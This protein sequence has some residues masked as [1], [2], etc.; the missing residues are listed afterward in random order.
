MVPLTGAPLM[1][2]WPPSCSTRSRIPTIPSEVLD[3]RSLLAD[4]LA[5]IAPCAAN[6]SA[7]EKN[8]VRPSLVREIAERVVVVKNDRHLPRN[9]CAAFEVGVHSDRRAELEQVEPLQLDLMRPIGIEG[10]IQDVPV[11]VE[12]HGGVIVVAGV[13]RVVATVCHSA[14]VR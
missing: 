12:R 3:E 6:R 5:V 4:P 7:C 2:S 14:F 11:S 10:A 13:V 8:G 1:A 9:R